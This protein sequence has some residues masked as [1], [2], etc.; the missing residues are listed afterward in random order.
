VIRD[1]RETLH[2]LRSD[3]SEQRSIVDALRTHLDR[4][5]ER[6]GLA[7]SLDLAGAE[8]LA[9]G[10][11]RELW[12]LALEAIT[13]VERHARAT[14]VAVRYDVTTEQATLAIADDGIGLN[15]TAIAA[16]RY[17]MIGMRERA[18]AIGAVIRFESSPG[19][20]TTVTVT[21]DR[22]RKPVA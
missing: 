5:A 14:T 7:V 13:N 8:R 19:R 10:A 12:R 17:G 11:E 3:V 1:V 6:S 22:T 16:D 18:A 9:P 4:V 20:G 2:D 15:P 21:I